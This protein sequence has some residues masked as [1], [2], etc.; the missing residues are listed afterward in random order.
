MVLGY[1]HSSLP[2]LRHTPIPRHTRSGQSLTTCCSR[3]LFEHPS[4][5]SLPP[6]LVT[7][8]FRRRSAVRRQLFTLLALSWGLVKLVSQ[9]PVMLTS[10]GNDVRYA[11]RML[12]KSP[13]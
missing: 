2:G 10:I 7:T 5:Q 13:G 3:L 12:M 1:F 6:R 11:L 4:T 9:E 8:N